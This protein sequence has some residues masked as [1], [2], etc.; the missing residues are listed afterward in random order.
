LALTLRVSFPE[1]DGPRSSK[2][3]PKPLL[4]EVIGNRV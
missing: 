1:L 2:V 3:C 4:L